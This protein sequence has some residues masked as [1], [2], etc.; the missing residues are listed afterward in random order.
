M[1]NTQGTEVVTVDL[2]IYPSKTNRTPQVSTSRTHN[3]CIIAQQD[4]LNLVVVLH[5]CLVSSPVGHLFLNATVSHFNILTG[6]GSAHLLSVPETQ[7][8]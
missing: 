3:S 1:S 8:E 5:V 6:S 4:C 2:A 7:I